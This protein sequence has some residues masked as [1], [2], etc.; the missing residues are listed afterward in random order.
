MHDVSRG[1]D[2][3]QQ[4]ILLFERVGKFLICLTMN[5]FV[6]DTSIKPFPYSDLDY[7]CLILN[8]D[9]TKRGPGYCHFNS[10][11]LFDAVFEAQTKY[12]RTDW[13]LKYDGFVDPLVCW[14]KAKRHF[15]IITICCTA[16]IMLK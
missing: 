15:K 12:F 9:Q 10:E 16:K 14:D 1:P 13:Q 7:V 6:T 2:V 5:P 4:M 3:T 11:L 8:F